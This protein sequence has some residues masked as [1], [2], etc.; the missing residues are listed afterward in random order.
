LFL[1][2]AAW[3]LDA[4]H[5]FDG[6]DRPSDEG[7][8]IRFAQVSLCRVMPL[9]NTRSRL[10]P[11]PITPWRRQLSWPISSSVLSP[12][13]RAGEGSEQ[14]WPPVFGSFIRRYRARKLR[15]RDECGTA[16]WVASC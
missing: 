2:K 12:H 1:A 9:G 5:A 11:L 7:D 6:R 3:Q 4:I 13:I 15:G 10:R 8:L 16:A 14:T